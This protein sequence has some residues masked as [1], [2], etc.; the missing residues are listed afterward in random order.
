MANIHWPKGSKYNN[1]LYIIGN[2]QIFSLSRDLCHKLLRIGREQWE[3]KETRGVRHIRIFTKIRF[4][5]RD[6]LSI[7]T[8]SNQQLQ[9][10][11]KTISSFL[12]SI[13][14]FEV[15][16]NCRGNVSIHLTFRFCCLA[17]EISIRHRL[18]MIRNLLL[19]QRILTKILTFLYL[20]L[21]FY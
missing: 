21:P 18:Y 7:V 19:E 10:I 9:E 11:Q 14:L 15:I 6:F 20:H 17:W 5:L 4:P 13:E 12:N 8:M 3:L 16:V 2:V 1:P